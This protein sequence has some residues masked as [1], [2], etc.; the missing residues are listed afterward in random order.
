MGMSVDTL[1]K[2]TPLVLDF[3][4]AMNLDLGTAFRVVQNANE[5]N[6]DA[7]KRYG[8]HVDDAKVKAEGFNAVLEVMQ[9]NFKGTAEEIAKSGIGPMKQFENTLGNFKELIGA[10]LLPGFNSLLKVI[11]NI[12]EALTGESKATE[13]SADRMKKA[14]QLIDS[15]NMSLQDRHV[16]LS[17]IK[18]DNEKGIDLILRKY[19]KEKETEDKINKLKVELSEGD[20]KRR[21]EEAAK[22]DKAR[23]ERIDKTKEALEKEY[24]LRRQIG[25]MDVEATIADIE[26]KIQ[27]ETIGSEKRK[28]LELALKDYKDAL[29]IDS[30]EKIKAIQDSISGN[31]ESN[32]VDMLMAEKSFGEGVEGIW[33]GIEKIILEAI[34]KQVIEEQAAATIRIAAEKA[35]AAAK[36]IS[37][38]AGIP[39]IGIVLGIAT[40]A[41]IMSKIG[42]MSKFHSGG[43]VPGPENQE[44]AVMVRGGEEILTPEQRR[45]GGGGVV[46]NIQFPNVTTFS[47]WMNA[48]PES[49]KQVTERKILPVLSILENEGKI[50]K[51]TVL[52]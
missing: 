35:V 7:L 17:Q 3:A 10:T 44:R 45:R 15:G 9:N 2:V 33:K 6:S 47:D 49:V 42:E 22:D 51:G 20:K 48:S 26:Q 1:E 40:A 34:V 11:I 16:L 23:E 12:G 36:A 25:S 30:A 27:A 31:L 50:K 5:G 46:V 21:K 29:S 18:T 28:A 8:I 32:I 37:A 4:S 13:I 14:K 52:V 24:D 19:E 41:A 43:V 38:Y 39:F